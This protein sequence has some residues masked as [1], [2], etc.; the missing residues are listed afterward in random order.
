VTVRE[1][2]HGG[3][4]RT[5]IVDQVGYRADDGVHH[6]EDQP[7][8]EVGQTYVLAVNREL[9]ASAAE[10]AAPEIN[11]IGGPHGA[12]ALTSETEPEVLESWRATIE[13]KTF[14]PGVPTK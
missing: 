12:T 6:L 3:V 10:G 9:R 2:L 11:V 13:R 5:V 7:L 8:L 14:P 4:P 1:S